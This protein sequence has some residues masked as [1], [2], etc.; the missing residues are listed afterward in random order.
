MNRETMTAGLTLGVL[1]L[2]LGSSDYF[3]KEHPAWNSILQ[4]DSSSSSQSSAISDISAISSASS[5]TV[6][7]GAS[8]SSFAGVKK[9]TTR[10]EG[11]DVQNLLQTQG[12]T[13]AAIA[14][15]VLIGAIAQQETMNGFVLLKNNDRT[16]LLAWID[17][18]NVKTIF[19]G[20]KQALAENFSGRVSDLVDE[21]QTPAQGAPRDILS[22]IDPS[23]SSERFLFVRIRT[24][25][26]EFHIA[27]G[28][29]ADVQ[30][31]VEALGQ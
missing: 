28:K 3:L 27:Q 18:P 8:S 24:R 6:I 12:Y 15:P 10:K 23:L 5:I 16:A 2:V 13:A 11:P 4:N 9:G 21:T 7:P 22:F 17:T 31:I 26:Y 30:A 20:L 25:L 19:A 1:L 14:E 29:E